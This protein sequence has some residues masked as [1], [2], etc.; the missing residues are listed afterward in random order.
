EQLSYTCAQIGSRTVTLTVGDA[1][2]NTASCTS[3][4]TISDNTPPVISQC[5]PGVTVNDC[6]AL[7]TDLT[8]GLTATDNCTN[9]ASIIQVPPAGSGLNLLGTGNT[10]T[11]TVTDQSGNTAT[12][13]NVVT[14]DDTVPPQFTACPANITASNQPGT[15][16]AQVMITTPVATDNCGTATVVRTGGLAENAV[17]PV[18]TTVQIYRAT[19]LGMNTSVCSFSVTISDT[20]AP[21]AVCSSPLVALNAQGT[22]SLLPAALNNGSSDNCTASGQLVFTSNGNLSF[23]CANIG[24][25]TVTLTVTDA[26]GNTATCT[27]VITVADLT[28]PVA[29]CGNLTRSLSGSSITV[30]ASEL[31]N[32]SSDNCTPAANLVFSGTGLTFGCANLG[33]NTVTLSVTDAMGNT[34]TCTAVITVTDN[35][36]PTAICKNLTVSLDASGMVSVAGTSL[37]NSSLDNC[38]AANMLQF[39]PVSTIFGCQQI[40]TNTVVLTVTDASG[41]SA[42]CS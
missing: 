37:N 40:G 4:V 18:G 13:T 39:T 16:G 15:C 5:P 42:T 11:F 41:N 22:G 7:V 25:N 26:A 33:A 3:T 30:N 12:C 14:V 35:T 21:V 19:D 32:G 31:N 10:I 27:S 2:G 17:F 34:G 24:T 20:Q 1:S 28:A 38:T 8:S 9:I 23:T 29:V 6:N 36:V